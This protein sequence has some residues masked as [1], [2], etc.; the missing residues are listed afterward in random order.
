MKVN[1][2]VDPLPGE[3]IAG[4]Q[5]T[6]SPRAD[7]QWHRRLNLYT[8]RTLSDTAL[9]AEQD[10]RA[11]RLATWGQTFSPGVISGLEITVDLESPPL[12]AE[13]AIPID[14]RGKDV[15]GATRRPLAGLAL[16][17]RVVSSLIRDEATDPK[18]RS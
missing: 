6:M 11:G 2:I 14:I 3:H 15:S 18:P 12:V 10:G 7:A 8:G 5:P 9:T 16:S 13:S 1:P 4:V 17:P